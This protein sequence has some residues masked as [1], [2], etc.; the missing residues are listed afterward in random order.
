M[1]FGGLF[2]G[3][4]Q[5]RPENNPAAEPV[6]PPAP[7]PAA[8]AYEP[9]SPSYPAHA[10]HAAPAMEA[11]PVEAPAELGADI[12]LPLAGILEKL[13]QDL[14]TKMTM[15]IEDLGDAT[16]AIPT[17]Q[18]MPQLALGSVKI[19]FGQLRGAAPELFRV[20]EEYDSLPVLLPL[21]VLLAQLNPNLLPRNPRQQRI[22]VP[23]EIKGP[24]G[25]NKADGVSFATSFMK[26]SPG[27]APRPQGDSQTKLT[28]RAVVTP[29]PAFTRP[30]PPAPVPPPPAA[31]PAPPAPKPPVAAPTPLMPRP[32]MP[33][34]PPVTPISP[35]SPIAPS[36]TPIPMP[37]AARPA[38]SAPIPFTFN[39]PVTPPAPPV[40]AAPVPPPPVRPPAPVVAPVSSTPIEVAPA[41]APSS[42]AGSRAITAS[43]ADLSEKWPEPLKAEIRQMNIGAARVSIPLNLL[44]GPLRK[45][46]VIMSWQNIRSLMNPPSAGASANDGIELELPLKIIVPMYLETASPI[47]PPL[48]V[49]V[50]RTIPNLFFGF[51]SAEMEAPVAAPVGEAPPPEPKPAPKPA[52]A[53]PAAPVPAPAAP[54]RV[55]APPVAPAP[56]AAPVPAPASPPPAP[57]PV[58]PMQPSQAADTNFFLPADTG[59]AA[60]A[61]A[62][63]KP[64]VSDTE[65]KRR[66]STPKEIVERA[67]AVPGVAGAVIALP[68]GLKVAAQVPAELNPD[69]VAAFIPQIFDRV[70]QSTRELRMGALN[71]LKFT[72]GN[73][74]W[75]IFRVNAV[76]FAA[77]GR[78]GE[79]L[80][81][82]DLAKLAA[83]LDRKTK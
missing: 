55:A 67:M 36:A 4:R 74:P 61:A 83:E 16:I 40:H 57:R 19:T 24:F 47:R 60:A 82:A 34:A 77:F 56:P 14:K 22:D 68:D 10:A 44:E 58:T 62:G 69:T 63:P 23:Q 32:P 65:I 80:P 11:A 26:A 43:V 5:P 6:A 72:V 18:I 37:P 49:S 2:K 13:P 52:A 1:N 21:N 27:P 75:K 73:V 53:V 8:P 71:N 3:W 59:Q 17:D 76:Y 9:P 33:A 29:P 12:E 46:R 78:P 35:I 7:V 39:K 64:I 42:A 20:A 41:A 51:P 79:R 38:P 15:R 45:G 70:G 28:P 25:A 54:L 81:T 31:A 30:A 50:D 48:R 66:L